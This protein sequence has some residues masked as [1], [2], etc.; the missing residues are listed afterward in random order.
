MANP[1]AAAILWPEKFLPGSTDNYVSNEVVVADL[2]FDDVW[3]YLADCS[4]WEAYY[5]NIGQITPPPTGTF[6]T[7]EAVGSHFNFATFGFPP[8]EIILEELVPPTA[9]TPGRMAWRAWLP[10]ATGD[11]HIEVYHAWI[12]E[13]APW[14]SPSKK[15]VRVLTQ[16]SQIGVPAKNLATTVP[17]PMLLGH[18]KWL[19]GLIAYAKEK[20]E[21]K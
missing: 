15:V 1:T 6:F 5:D 17:S 21:K 19:D 3:P 2:D 20:K 11:D 4:H 10:G 16:E 9:T 8:L 14:S 7:P 12:V 18:Q 13:N